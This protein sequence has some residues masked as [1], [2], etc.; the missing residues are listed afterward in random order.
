MPS[1]DELLTNPE[2]HTLAVL[3]LSELL[4]QSLTLGTHTGRR[5]GPHRRAYLDSR[6]EALKTLET[7]TTW[8]NDPNRAEAWRIDGLRLE[9]RGPKSPTELAHW[10]LLTPHCQPG[11]PIGEGAEVYA[12][13]LVDAVQWVDAQFPLPS[14]WAQLDPK[15]R[16]WRY[17][18]K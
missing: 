2:E 9:L 13:S 7:S 5:V 12:G 6:A 11:M 4:N 18:S 15:A 17:A 10:R 1:L 8:W 3:A 14:W 16:P